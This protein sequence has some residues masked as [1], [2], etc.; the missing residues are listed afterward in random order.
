VGGRLMM[1][2]NMD[3]GE[4]SSALRGLLD[5]VLPRTGS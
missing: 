2:A 5:R 4:R 1:F 3:K